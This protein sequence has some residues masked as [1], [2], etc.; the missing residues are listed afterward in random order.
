MTGTNS[1]AGIIEAVRK[2]P[3][4]YVG[5]T[6]VYGLHHLVYFLLDAVFSEA[7]RGEC[8]DFSLEA[9]VDGSISL[10]STSRIVPP[11]EL[12]GMAVGHAFYMQPETYDWGWSNS[13][14]VALALSSRYQVDLWSEGRQWCLLGEQGRPVDEPQEVTP[15]EPLP[16]EASRG[17]RI[18]VVPDATIFD[19]PAF[20]TEMLSRRCQEL[21]TL[22]P[23][24]RARFTDHR[25]GQH[26]LLYYPRGLTQWLEERIQGLPRVHPEPLSFDVQWEG[27]RVRCTLQWCEVDGSVWS[28]AN[29]VR[30]RRQG[31]HVDGVFLALRGALSELSGERVP[32]FSRP[33]LERGLMAIISADGPEERMSF[34]GPTKDLLATEGLKW[35]VRRLLRPVL[36]EALREH[37][38]TPWLLEQ[39]R[40]PR[41]RA[42]P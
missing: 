32:V 8:G 40:V 23:G 14:P 42:S 29:T 22:A 6:G 35:A 10:F 1:P 20:D 26:A 21:T 25:T 24:L 3:G 16:I 11:G 33:R 27:L 15:A 2:R 5:D 19:K 18:R 17:M 28:Y 4:M 41:R 7:R 38:L 39:G 9:G 34:K 30:T 37:P 31:V 13:V 36:V 12:V